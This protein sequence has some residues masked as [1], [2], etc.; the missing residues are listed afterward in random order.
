[1]SIISAMP[2]RFWRCTTMLSVSGRPAARTAAANFSLALD[3][4]PARPA[5][6]SA[7]AGSWSWKLSCTWRSPASA[8]RRDLALAAQRAGGDEIAVEAER[9]PPRRSARRDRAAPSARR[10]RNGPAARRAPPPRAA[11]GAIPRRVELA[12][13]ALELDRVG[14]IGA[15]QRTAMRQ[16]GQQG[17]RRVNR[18]ASA[19]HPLSARS[20]SIAVTS[21]A[22][23]S[24]GACEAR[25]QRV[26]DRADARLRRRPA[27][28][29]RPPARRAASAARAPS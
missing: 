28:G 17:Q 19:R 26:D 11:R 6:R 9:W 20:C 12:R 7:F 14:A 4:A 29:S 24:R 21:P 8:K 18:P 3:S 10:R 5:M 1:M 25:G 27:A 15:A 2:S 16:L 22:I 23:S 13:R